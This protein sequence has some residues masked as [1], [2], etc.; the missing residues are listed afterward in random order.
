MFPRRRIG[1]TQADGVCQW[2]ILVSLFQAER[3]ARRNTVQPLSRGRHELE[4]TPSHDYAS[5]AVY[6]AGI[7][8]TS[9]IDIPKDLYSRTGG[10]A[11]QSHADL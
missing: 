2:S 4:K 1:K 11:C 10:L 5:P 9:V 3:L 7:N 6:S 8:S